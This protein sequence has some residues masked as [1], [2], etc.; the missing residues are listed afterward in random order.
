[1]TRPYPTPDQL[2]AALLDVLAPITRWR[3]PPPAEGHPVLINADGIDHHVGYVGAVRLDPDGLAH[4]Y[5]ATYDDAGRAVPGRTIRAGSHL[6]WGVTTTIAGGDPARARWALAR[7]RDALDGTTLTSP[8]LTTEP[9]L[10]YFTAGPIRPDEGTDPVRWFTTLRHTTTARRS[11]PSN[12]PE[13]GQ[14]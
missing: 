5:I 10:E 11:S 3:I 7:L 1:M 4:P 6:S 14:P 13:E 2:H 8:D 12:S 9:L